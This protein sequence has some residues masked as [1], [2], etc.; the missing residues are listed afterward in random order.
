MKLVVGAVGGAVVCAVACI[1]AGALSVAALAQPPARCEA[2][3]HITHVE[4]KL[5]QTAAAMMKDRRLDILVLG[6]GSSTLP[7]L[8]GAKLAYPA[9]L[10]A[11]LQERFKDVKVS[12]TTDVKSRRTT[13]DMA[14]TLQTALDAKPTLVIWQTGT[15]DAMRGVDL[16]G[17]R[18]ALKGGIK[19]LQAAGIDVILVNMQYSPRTEMMLAAGAY[20]DNMRWVAQ[21]RDVPLFDR[22]GLMRY[23]SEAARFDFSAPQ[24]ASLV[25]QQVHDCIGRLLADLIADTVDIGGAQKDG[26]DAEKK[27]P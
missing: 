5:P 20:A 8:E 27:E 16:D 6:S 7:G 21:Q 10:M 18:R 11:A 24:A 1:L 15:F 19:K 13:A 26:G 25:A 12:L 17:F 9:R 2:P 3:E 23:W 22:L 14:A 4:G